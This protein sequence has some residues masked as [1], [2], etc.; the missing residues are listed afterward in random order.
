MKTLTLYLFSIVLLLNPTFGTPYN[1]IDN[2]DYSSTKK[3]A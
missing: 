1:S 2:D 3:K